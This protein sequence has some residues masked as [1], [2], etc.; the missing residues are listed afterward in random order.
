MKNILI[1]IWLEILCIVH[2][3]TYHEYTNFAKRHKIYLYKLI[4]HCFGFRF[5]HHYCNQVMRIILSVFNLKNDFLMFQEGK[6]L[7]QDMSQRN[8]I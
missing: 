4:G 6:E 3:M 7:R 1:D 5:D 2:C 8:V